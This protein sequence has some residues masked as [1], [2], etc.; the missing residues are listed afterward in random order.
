MVS[1]AVDAFYHYFKEKKTQKS[2]THLPR[3]FLPNVQFSAAILGSILDNTCSGV[4]LDLEIAPDAELSR[5]R[6]LSS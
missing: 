3:I 6:W 5:E 4:A 2:E 1:L